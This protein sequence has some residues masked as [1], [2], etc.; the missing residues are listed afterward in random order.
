MKTKISL[1]PSKADLAQW[2]EHLK[3]LLSEDLVRD[4]KSKKERAA[5]AAV[6]KWLS[7]NAIVA[8]KL[9]K[10]GQYTTLA[11]SRHTW[12]VIEKYDAFVLSRDTVDKAEKLLGIT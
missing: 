3:Y 11:M 9:K 5:I 10:S 6:F 1:K 12:K 2:R 4:F 7:L 8:W